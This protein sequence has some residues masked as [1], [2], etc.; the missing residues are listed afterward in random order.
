MHRLLEIIDLWPLP[1]RQCREGSKQKSFYLWGALVTTWNDWNEHWGS[2][3]LQNVECITLS[4]LMCV[5]RAQTC[6]FSMVM[7]P[8]TFNYAYRALKLLSNIRQ[9]GRFI[10]NG[11]FEHPSEHWSAE[12]SL[13]D[14]NAT[15]DS[16]TLLYHFC[17]DRKKAILCE[18]EVH[19]K[20]S[21]YQL[22]QSCW[23]D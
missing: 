4:R 5:S 18:R 9:N 16:V 23:G 21:S 11:C 14:C 19:E 20:C 2:F 10:D 15:S 22:Y 7:F 12:F 1:P 17:T 3:F 6:K 13:G 8:K